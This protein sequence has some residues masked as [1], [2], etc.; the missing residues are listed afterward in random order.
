MTRE[1]ACM[2]GTIRNLL[3]E[4]DEQDAIPLPMVTSEI[5]ARIVEFCRYRTGRDERDREVR[6]QDAAFLSDMDTP[7][8]IQVILAA[9]YLDVACLLDLTC[10][11]VA[12]MVR[13]KTPSEIREMFGIED[14]MTP[15]DHREVDELERLFQ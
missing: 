3:N 11:R 4:I 12:D 8:L 9:N 7:T 14:D 13:G 5:L 1:Q 6:E 10:Q 15:D 2:S